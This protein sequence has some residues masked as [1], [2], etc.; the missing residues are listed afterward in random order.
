MT[1]FTEEDQA[2]WEAWIAD[3]P[4]SLRDWLTATMPRLDQ[5]PKCWRLANTSGHYVVVSFHTEVDQA[6]GR[7]VPGGGE[8]TLKVRH[9]PGP[10][11]RIGDGT[12]GVTVFGV[13]AADLV[14]CG[15]GDFSMESTLS[16]QFGLTPTALVEPEGD[17]EHTSGEFVRLDGGT[18]EYGTL[19]GRDLFTPE[20]ENLGTRIEE[21]VEPEHTDD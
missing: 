14:P 20:S 15:C 11:G 18:F 7:S 4:E 9:V 6:T 13:P 1:A 17:L 10:G 16:E 19:D 12:A 21:P 8:V 2:N 5:M 3:R